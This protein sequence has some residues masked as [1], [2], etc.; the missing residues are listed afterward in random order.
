MGTRW[1]GLLA[2]LGVTTGDGRRFA[3]DAITWR[4][5]P[6]ALK[7]QRSDDQGHD[8]SVIVGSLDDINIAT[9][10]DA[11][12]NGWVTDEGVSGLDFDTTTLGVWGTGELFDDVDASVL[13]RLAEDVG[14]ARLLTSRKVIGPSVDAG[15]AEAILAEPG[16]EEPIS[17]E[18]WEEILD[19]AWEN[20]TE[21]EIEVLFT[22]YQIAAATLVGIPAFAQCL[23]FTLEEVDDDAE[24]GALVASVRA[25]GWA[26]LP[27]AARDTG[28]N[29][30]TAMHNLADHFALDGEA[31]D[32]DGFAAGFLWRN[33][34]ANPQTRGAYGYGLVDVVDGKLSIVPKAVT[35]AAKSLA[36]GGGSKCSAT[37]Q[38]RMREVVTAIYARMADEFED[39]ELTVPWTA[40]I[41]AAAQARTDLAVTLTASAAPV[42]DLTLFVDPELTGVTPITITDPDDAGVRRVFGH[43]AAF[44][45]CHAGIHD[46]CTTAPR[47]GRQYADFHRYR[48]TAGGAELPVP[49]GRLTVAH[50]S[51]TGKCRC[52]PGIDDHACNSLG[53]GS[54]IAHYDQAHAVAYV[55][56]GE[57]QFGIWV[58][59]IVAPEAT[60]ADVAKLGLQKVSGDW[61][62]VGGNLELV[63][64][65]TLNRE[66]PG[67]PLPRAT[68]ANGRQASL[69]AAG[70]V[71]PSR[72]GR[73]KRPVPARPAAAGIDY[74]RMA[75]AM[76][77][78]WLAAMKTP[79]AQ[80]A[81]DPPI[82]T[83]TVPPD[84][85]TVKAA[86][87]AAAEMS[88]TAQSIAAEMD[89]DMLAL[90]AADLAAETEGFTH[91]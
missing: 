60:D 62:E 88:A 31:P 9:V 48:T 57:D 34:D 85:A 58:S 44:G 68:M 46:V 21:P 83:G 66:K 35:T 23:P 14:E 22:E 76:T 39:A 77:R 51:L 25:N 79:D 69:V 70:A 6:L 15:A 54:T 82:R 28:W 17:D 45:V 61:R 67:F 81:F 33:D 40:S 65:L 1:R 64:V 27:L 56:A 84:P 5:L 2:P 86:E 29:A 18:R 24:A 89:A 55:R 30:T 91:V 42:T 3:T 50:G 80:L 12:A 59:G 90:Q 78:A 37:E 72:S 11:L 8:D 71:A 7:W 74:D 4:E 32:W 36:D 43:V 26:S 73:P 53:L 19:D 75:A 10:A 63:E 47:S 49:T 52:C 13:P 87:Q 16:S 38:T 41:S 20:G